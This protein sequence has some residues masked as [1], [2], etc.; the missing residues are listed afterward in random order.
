MSDDV[1]RARGI[2]SA[3][4]A[5]WTELIRSVAADLLD[6]EPS[7]GEWSALA[8]LRH[9][10]D[11]ERDVFQVRLEALLAGRDFA[12]YDPDAEAE[13]PSTGIAAPELVAEFA[14][15]REASLASLRR[16]GEA[17]LGRTARHAELGPVTL[18][19]LLNEWA[20][21]DLNH[22]VQAERGMMQP[23]IRGSGPW[24]VYFADHDRGDPAAEGA[25][26]H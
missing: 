4:P 8:C 12:A 3:T 26:A 24:R 9:L 13:R 7:P 22:T 10:A 6:L 1:E 11:S 21:H 16:L 14:S 2:L 17:D 25:S 23:F 15:L 18:A 5:R 19:E 20:A